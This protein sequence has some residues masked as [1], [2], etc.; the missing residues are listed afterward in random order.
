MRLS[1]FLTFSVLIFSLFLASS[2]L[3]TSVTMTYEGHQG[4]SAQN[5]SPFVGY[6]YYVSING[7][8]TYTPLLCDAY[9]NEIALGQTWTA[10]ASPSAMRS[11]KRWP[12]GSKPVA[13]P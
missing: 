5:G 8:S 2:A 1:R 4:V 3:A 12:V 9:D 6:P 11:S 13:A 10:T 7:S